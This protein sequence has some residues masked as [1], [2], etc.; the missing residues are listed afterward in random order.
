MENGK[1]SIHD[2]F[3]F[4]PQDRQLL[5]VFPSLFRQFLPDLLSVNID[6][7]F[8]QPDLMMK[9]THVRLILFMMK[10]ISLFILL[11]IMLY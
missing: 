6:K 1:K 2:E 8:S 7:S 3:P 4:V 11:E 9:I 5:D 10:G